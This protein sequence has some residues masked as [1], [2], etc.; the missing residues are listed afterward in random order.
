MGRRGWRVGGAGHIAVASALALAGVACDGGGPSS[1]QAVIGG[2]GSGAA[3]SGADAQPSGPC[4]SMRAPI[5]PCGA[6]ATGTIRACGHDSDGQP[7]PTGY[8]E[9][10]DP[11]G[12]KTY[13]CATSWGASTGYWFDQPDQFM[14]DPQSCCGGAPSPVAAPTAPTPPI[15]FLGNP[16]APH[17]IKP[18]ETTQPGDGSLREDPFAIVVQDSGGTA[19]FQAALP[20]WQSWAGDGV[21]HPAPDGSG[22]YYFPQSVIINYAIIETQ[23]GRPIVV[24]GPEV[25]TTSDEMSPLGHPTMGACASGGGAALAL[26]AGEL[27][28]TTLSNHSGRF[29]YDASVTQDALT[30][31]QSLFN[32][33][34]IPVTMTIYYP[35]KPRTAP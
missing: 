17:D 32:C 16:H 13:V 6:V 15:G 19:A 10:Q 35:P 5:D 9:I 33:L 12:S 25:S 7:T 21:P 28:G 22:A 34:G 4:D 1:S 29:G 18:Q 2:G 30:N 14:S 24:I 31:A 20:M 26:T 8:L 23:D 3:G 27:E 11:E